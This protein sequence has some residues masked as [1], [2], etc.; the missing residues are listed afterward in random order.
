MPLESKFHLTDR[1]SKF[2][3][4]HADKS[5]SYKWGTVPNIYPIV[6][7]MLELAGGLVDEFLLHGKDIGQE[8]FGKPVPSDRVAGV[9]NPL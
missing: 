4:F 6:K 8:P 9:M 5:H 3:L 7:M 1:F 2:I